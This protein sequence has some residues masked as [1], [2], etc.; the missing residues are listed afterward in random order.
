[1]PDD[2]INQTYNS[3]MNRVLG[4]TGWSRTATAKS[5]VDWNFEVQKWEETFLWDSVPLHTVKY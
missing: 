5:R 3:I 1:M 4:D 2:K